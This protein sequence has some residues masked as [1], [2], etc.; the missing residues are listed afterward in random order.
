MFPDT[1]NVDNVPTLPMFGCAEFITS[2]AS[3]AVLTVP[4]IFAATTL[5]MPPPSPVIMPVVTP[6][7]P[8]TVKLVNVPVDVM[9]G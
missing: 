2:C 8:V 1:S 3:T 7:A 4:E 6:K 5:D 9:F